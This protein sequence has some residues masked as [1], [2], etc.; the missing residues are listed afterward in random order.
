MFRE[1]YGTFRISILFYGSN[2]STLYVDL[3]PLMSFIVALLQELAQTLRGSEI[4]IAIIIL[5]A[6]YH[7][8]T[9]VSEEFFRYLFE[10]NMAGHCHHVVV[11]I[12]NDYD[13]NQKDT[14]R[15][16]HFWSRSQRVDVKQTLE[17]FGF[18]KKTTSANLSK[19]GVA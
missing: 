16:R 8:A 9:S 14:H 7:F 4:Q 11:R 5:S 2:Y 18:D 13:L 6:T 12:T 10:E 17:V 3:Y 19:C 1:R 15:R